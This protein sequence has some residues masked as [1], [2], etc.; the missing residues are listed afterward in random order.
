MSDQAPVILLMGP[1]ASGKTDLALALADR[2]P[3]GLISVDSALVYRGMDI[4]S[5]KPSP[6]ILAAYPHALVDICEPE[7]SYSAAR[8]RADALVEIQRIQA[9]G[10]IPLLVGGTMLYYQALQHGLSELP[11]ADASVRAQLD[12]ELAQHGLE[13]MHLLLQQVDPEAA[14]RIHA[15]DPQRILRALEVYRIAG[16]P[17]SLLHRQQAKQAMPYPAIKLVRAPDQRAVLHERIAL[18]FEQMLV[19]GFEQEVRALMARPGFS[20]LLP[21]MRAVGY[22]QMLGYLMGEYGRQEMLE[23]GIAATR[24]LAKRQFTWLRRETG[25]HW[26]NDGQ[27]QAIDTIVALIKQRL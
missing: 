2:L 6:D 9:E 7:E 19:Q 16:Q 11:Q 12:S 25:A 4:G 3:V 27:A 5:A 10:K 26:I 1:T 24:Q 17:M 13:H 15:N 23:K 20:P 14:A 8:F 22:R 18:R 21:S